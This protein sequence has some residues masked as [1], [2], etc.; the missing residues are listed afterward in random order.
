[1]GASEGDSN[2]KVGGWVRPQKCT[3]E[4]ENITLFHEMVGEVEQA[5]RHKKLR[6]LEGL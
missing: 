4:R 1:M 6:H 5:G 3:R 2:S